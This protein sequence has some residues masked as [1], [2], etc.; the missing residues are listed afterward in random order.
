MFE[1]KEFIRKQLS[2]VARDLHSKL[3]VNKLL[4]ADYYVLACKGDPDTADS[5]KEL[6]IIRNKNRKI[7]DKLQKIRVAILAVKNAY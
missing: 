2:L 7:R 4:E 5:F 1:S 3:A 6:N